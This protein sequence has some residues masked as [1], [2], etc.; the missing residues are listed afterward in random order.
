MFQL[1]LPMPPYWEAETQQIAFALFSASGDFTA[2]QAPFWLAVADLPGKPTAQPP[3]RAFFRLTEILN[4]RG[5]LILRFETECA[6]PPLT[7]SKP[8]ADG[9]IQTQTAEIDLGPMP[10][11]S[12]TAVYDRLMKLS[13]RRIKTTPCFLQTVCYIPGKKSETVFFR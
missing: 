2:V 7:R 5:R 8:A 11:P 6:L 1:I 10:L 3:F 9:E 4:R 13:R 12:E